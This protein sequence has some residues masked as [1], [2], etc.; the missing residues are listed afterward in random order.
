[1]NSKN[2]ETLDPHRLLLNLI[3]KIDLRRKDKYFALSSL[4]IY[5]TWNNINKSYKNNKFKIS[6][7]T[8]NEEFELLNGS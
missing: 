1:M 3:D 8:W 7:P 6:A 2:S 4:S 5:Y